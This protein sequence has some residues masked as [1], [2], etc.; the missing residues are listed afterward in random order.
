MVLPHPRTRYAKSGQ[1]AIAYQVLGDGPQ[2]LIVV[3]PGLSLMD[4]AWDEPALATFWRRLSTF[5]R[6]VVLDKRGTGLSDRVEGVPTLEDRMDDVRAVMDAVGL[7]RAALLGGSEAGPITALFA[8]TYPERVTALILIE[9]M[10]KWT[11]TA[12]FPW[13]YSSEQI[14]TQSDYVEQS[15]GSG[16]SG[17]S[18]FAPSLSGDTRAREWVAR[19]E[20]LTGTPNA[21]TTFLAMNALIDVRPILEAILVPT[22]VIQRE[23]DQVVDVHNGRY[24]ADHIDGSKYVELPGE[25]H[26][27]WV[28]D[29]NSILEEIEE[30]ITGKRHAPDVDR[31][32]KSLLFTDIV[33][34]TEQ[35]SR[36]GDRSWRDLLD[37]H[38]S[39]V[40][41]QLD[42]FEGQEVNTTGDGFVA[43]F[44]GPARA[45]RCAQA[46]VSGATQLGVQ[47]R[48]GIH[49]G[50]CERRGQ[51]LAGIAVHVAARVAAMARPD[52]VLVTGTVRDLVA[53]SGIGFDDR[54]EHSLKGVSG[55][56]LVLA[57]RA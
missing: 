5:T 19:V 47:V 34:S 28:G 27:W 10:V 11:A 22:L 38:D 16:W 4:A 30:F 8:A 23:A 41:S 14:Q 33:A 44:D 2:S 50:E 49:T 18:W 25:D 31:V 20:R 12:D 43:C 57:A 48:A 1:L 17:E 21:M 51:D 29:A 26:W 42:R 45:I 36:L 56:W 55:R 9:A 32:L 39:M 54:G 7:D 24:Y 46:I 52:E 3:P 6:L 15:W 35:V 13:G 37:L 53:G 40:R